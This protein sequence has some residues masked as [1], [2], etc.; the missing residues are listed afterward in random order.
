MRFLCVLIILT[1]YASGANL[2]RDFSLFKLES[3]DKSAPTLLLMGGIHGDEAGAYYATDVFLRHYHITKGAVWVVPVVNPHGMFANMRGV[4]GD[5]NRKFAT[6]SKNDPDFHSIQKIKALLADE[7]IDISM[8]LHDGSGYWRPT[9]INNMLNPMRWGNC[10][11]IDQVD[12]EGVKFGHIAQFVAQMV[13]DINLHI[14]HPTHRYHINNTNTKAKN[15]VEQLKALTFFSLSLNKPALTNEASKELDIP[16]RVFYHLLAIESLLGQLGIG[17]K[18]DFDLSVDEIKALISKEVLS[19]TIANAIT[20]PLENLRP[21][22]SYFPLPKN[23]DLKHIDITS[24]SHLLGLVANNNHIELK[25]GA[26]SLTSIMPEFYHFDNSLQSLELTIDGKVI[27]ANIGS[28]VHVKDTIAFSPLKGYRIN[29]I[30]YV[31]PNDSSKFP[32]ESGISIKKADFI[33]RFSLDK[34]AQVYRAEIY[35]GEHFSGMITISFDTPKVAK[36]REFKAIAY[37]PAPLDSSTKL[38]LRESSQKAQTIK[39]TKVALDSAKAPIKDSAKATAK[40]TTKESL[41]K[42]LYVK[43]SV[44]INLRQAPS[45]NATILAKLSQYTQVQVL[46]SS[47]KWLKV[48]VHNK[49]GYVLKSLLLDSLPPHIATA[50]ATQNAKVVESKVADSNKTLDSSPLSPS[51]LFNQI[52]VPKKESAE[53]S[54]KMAKVRVNAAYIRAMP[55]IE[56]GAVAKAPKGR[57][58]Q[59]LS[60]SKDS[61]GIEWAKIYYNFNGKSGKRAIEGYVA[62]RLLDIE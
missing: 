61:N 6:L 45:T 16:T 17:F 35:K 32:D 1:L 8:H 48:S 53:S 56:S 31:N 46:E 36:K 20:L 27:Q 52:E 33:P 57:I 5:M 15:D 9:H 23:I 62:R 58:M 22:L 34:S 21:T 37:T 13:A 55:S 41:P 26:K 10:S 30:G 28:I 12:L 39:E 18:R 7:N 14:L 19:A 42:V 47:Q 59:V 40:A 54:A 24:N 2:V 51:A 25:Y 29:I 3:S 44:G 38:A 11:V 43:S 60:I 49:Q 4:Y 50:K